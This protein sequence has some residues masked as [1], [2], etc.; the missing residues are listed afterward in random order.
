MSEA[1]S[2]EV[3][4][5]EDPVGYFLEDLTYHG[6]TERTRDAHEPALRPAGR[7]LKQRGPGPCNNI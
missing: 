7:V 5:V 3:A 4:A 6:K 1:R 2:G